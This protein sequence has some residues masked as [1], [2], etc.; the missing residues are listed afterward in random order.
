[1]SVTGGALI[2]NDTGKVTILDDDSPTASDLQVAVGDTS[3][4]EGGGTKPT[5]AGFVVTLNHRPTADVTV[6]Y[7]LLSDSAKAPGDFKYKTGT[8]TFKTTQSFKAVSVA[9]I[10]D[11]VNE[12][13]ESFKLVLSSPSAGLTIKRD[14]GVATILNDD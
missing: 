7:A 11:F 3:L 8:L 10:A 4:Y 13:D 9:V 2:A 14:T 5:Q 12:P 6:H 1:S